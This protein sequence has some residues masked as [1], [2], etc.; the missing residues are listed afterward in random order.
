MCGLIGIVQGYDPK[1]SS[2]LS[3]LGKGLEAL[4]GFDATA[5]DASARL[6]AACALVE[7]LAA[8]LLVWAGFRSLVASPDARTNAAGLARRLADCAEGIDK[9]LAEGRDGTAVSERLAAAAVR[10][11][12]L[13]WKLERDALEN[14]KRV[15][16]LRDG[17]GTDKLLFE[18]WRLNLIFNQLERL[19]V[20]GR[21]S[22]GLGT[23]V[24]LS[25]QSWKAF[26]AAVEKDGLAG[27]LERRRSY[28][29]F[30]D[31]S[32]VLSEGV[33][34]MTVAFAHKIAREVGE[35]GANVRELRSRAKRDRLLRLALGREDGLVQTFAH[36]RW[37]SNGIINEANCHPL[38]NE[39][40][41]GI[42]SRALAASAV[43]PRVVLGALN[44]DIDNYPELAARHSAETGRPIPA[45]ITTDAKVIPVEIDRRFQGSGPK[46]FEDAF[47]SAIRA[48]EGSTAIASIGS[49][50]PGTYAIALKGSGQAVYVGFLP[51]GGHIFASELYGVVEVAERYY[52]LNGEAAEYVFLQDSGDI[53]VTRYDGTAV[54]LGDKEIKKAQITTRD[55]DR[56][57]FDHYLL[58]E[59]TE[60]PRSVRKTL[61]GKFVIE[62]E[63]K[64]RFLLGDEVIPEAVKKVLL[65]KKLRKVF[66]LGQGTACVAARAVADFL[67]SLCA[68]RGIE[69]RGMPA[70]ELSGFHLDRV[71]ASTICIAISQSG[72]T[73]DTNRTVDLARQRGAHVLCVV[74]RRNSDLVDKS[75][76]VLYTSDGRDVEMSVASTKAFYC[77]VVGGY[78]LSLALADVAGFISFEKNPGAIRMLREL[79]DLPRR[80][81]EVL[82]STRDRVRAAAQLALPRRH[83]ALVGSG[84]LRHAADEI[85]IKLS[86][87]CYKSIAVDTI[88][89]KKH[90]DLSSEPLIL[91]CAAGLEGAAAADA[92]K[93]V[94]IFRAHH[95]APIVVCDRGETRFSEYALATVE[96]PPAAARLALL[97]NALVGHLVGYE[98]ARAID[99]LAAPLRRAR[100]ATEAALSEARAAS[101]PVE[102]TQKRYRAALEPLAR[103]TFDAVARGKWNCAV[104]PDLTLRVSNALRLLLGQIPTEEA[105]RLARDPSLANV[106]DHS[107]IE[108][109][110]GIDA[111]R[112]PIDAIKHQAKTVTVGIS[113]DGA[114]TRVARG[115]LATALT[116]AGAEV[117]KLIDADGAALSALAPAIAQVQGATVYAITGL[118]PL[119]APTNDSRIQVVKKTGVAVKIRSR[120]DAGCELTGTKRRLVGAPRVLVCRG[121]RDKR[122]LI[123]CPLY[124]RGLVKGLGLLHVEFVD[125]LATRERARALKAT[126]RYEDLRCSVTEV[127]VAWDDRLL[128]P[129]PLA[130]LLTAPVE[131]LAETIVKLA[132]SAGEVAAQAKTA[133]K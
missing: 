105:Y 14:V 31:G 6:D 124:D 127:D 100:E 88:E 60:S 34:G 102:S 66:V 112:R 4:A 104:E 84:P 35:L 44:G 80:M 62:G 63:E 37:A 3:P 109:T 65:E 81:E 98:C 28:R 1:A 43:L 87:L 32:V 55:I 68:E 56:A 120:A 23:V 79:Q 121:E 132:R 85:R 39:V 96:V 110:R 93:E 130:E 52:K 118:D 125:T 46:G 9:R 99:A 25:V 115:V 113:R 24:H 54:E 97:L 13:A 20:R 59:I 26:A 123:M 106:L 15:G 119:G 2:D 70:T 126:G 72:T 42:G 75:H 78:I 30:R 90:I 114:A 74:N 103:E 67:G 33:T 45:G 71:D 101:F 128:D 8:D 107:L 117:T 69:V 64:A 36:T 11:R 95:A 116:E 12:D 47:V 131:R 73:T 83:W 5:A 133:E 21:D 7:G 38:S 22:G 91:V 94:A 48:F 122:A 27:E 19:E 77:Q 53:R 49:E 16:E 89:D 58:K 129:V 92:V 76:G 10:A 51:R 41:G 17:D 86:E 111:L 40:D 57:G 29:D 82:Q 61:R 50:A 108:L 18:L